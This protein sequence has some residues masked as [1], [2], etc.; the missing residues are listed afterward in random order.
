M[1][2]L[3]S[4]LLIAVL[5]FSCPLFAESGSKNKNGQKKQV[6]QLLKKL[7]R[8]EKA[9]AKKFNRLSPEAKLEVIS[10]TSADNNSDDDDLNDFIEGALDLNKCSSDSDDDGLDDSDEIENGKDPSDD[11][12]DDDGYEDG[13]EFEVHGLI[14]SIDSGSLNIASINYLLNENTEYLDDDNNP[15]T[16]EDFVVGDC[17]EVEGHLSGGDYVV[18]KV[19]E[20][21]DC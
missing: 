10:K 7:N 2:K 13:L 16:L 9:L 21:D 17:T 3:I 8:S 18:E 14:E 15:A 6:L 20:D 19:K 5:L 1:K 12:S 4:V 11:D